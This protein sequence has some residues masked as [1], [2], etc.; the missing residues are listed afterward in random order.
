VVDGSVSRTWLDLASRATLHTWA[1][2]S[3]TE[4]EYIENWRLV[5]LPFCEHIYC[6]KSRPSAYRKGIFMWVNPLLSPHYSEKAALDRL[7]Q[8]GGGMQSGGTTPSSANP[9]TVR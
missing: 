3:V 2:K 4:I 9:L 8:H 1:D 6:L 7:R 5:S